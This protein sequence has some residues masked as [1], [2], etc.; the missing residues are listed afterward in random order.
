[1]TKSET[2]NR[3][4]SWK[5]KGNGNRIDHL[6]GYNLAVNWT[7]DAS[8]APSEGAGEPGAELLLGIA[9][10]GLVRVKV[11]LS[12]DCRLFLNQ[13]LHCMNCRRHLTKTH[14]YVCIRP[15]GVGAGKSIKWLL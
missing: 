6:V 15:S 3:S 8:T 1:M 12:A 14:A 5:T 11:H 10:L 13:A 9:R 7:I 4:L 2:K